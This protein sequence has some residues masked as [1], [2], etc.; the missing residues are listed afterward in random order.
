MYLAVKGGNQLDDQFNNSKP[1]ITL[2]LSVLG[3]I[4]IIKL[5]IN[6]TRRM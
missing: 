5:I 3:M 1:W 6:Q 4:A 2:G